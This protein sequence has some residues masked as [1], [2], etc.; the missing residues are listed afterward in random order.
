MTKLLILHCGHPKTGTSS[1]QRFLAENTENLA[2]KGI[3][4]PVLKRRAVVDPAP[5]GEFQH[6]PVFEVLSKKGRA[7]PNSRLSELMSAIKEKEHDVLVLSSESLFRP[8]FYT[9]QKIIP[10]YFSS[11]GYRIVTVSYLRDQTDRLNSAYTQQ[12]KTGRPVGTIDT[13]LSHQLS[14]ASNMD[15]AG[16][17]TYDYTRLLQKE[18]LSWGEQVWRPF[19]ADVKSSGIEADFLGTIA[20]FCSSAGVPLPVEFRP[21]PRANDGDGTVLVATAR[22]LGEIVAMRFKGLKPNDR[23]RRR[24]S[25][26]VFRTASKVVSGIVEKD[27]KYQ[28]LTPSRRARIVDRFSAGN[29]TV[30]AQL[31]GR[32]WEEI[33]PRPADETL[34]CND[35]SETENRALKDLFQTALPIA[36]SRFQAALANLENR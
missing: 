13:F 11:L 22:S 28:G 4:Y 21:T 23:D 5:W 12:S 10:E 26:Q 18:H 36:R 31:W 6:G 33:F 34:V 7:G 25:S 2:E 3:L 20:P 27:P 8:L 16:N 32:P 9:Q 19:S 15:G 14:K 1:L 30:A 24:A 35:L 17:S 29:E